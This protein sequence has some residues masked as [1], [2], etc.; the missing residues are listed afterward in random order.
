MSLIT[1]KFKSSVLSTEAAYYVVIPDTV[2]E[3]IPVVYLLH[4]YSGDHT[5]WIRHSRCERYANGRGVALV[6][7]D[8]G[9]S[10]FTDMRYGGAY[11]THVAREVFEHS[12]K[13]F[14]LSSR[15]DATFVA[16][17]SMGG[18]GAFKIAL[19]EPDTYAAACSM[20]GALCAHEYVHDEKYKGLIEQLYGPGITEAPEHDDLF[21]L[22]ERVGQSGGARPRMLQFC[23]TE[24]YLYPHNEKFRRFMDGKGFDYEYRECPGEHEWRLWDAWLPEALDFFLGR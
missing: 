6:M 9:N 22:V 12:H 7:P 16:G 2:S 18:Y 5:S 24:D 17:L 3:D 4:G 1:C 20:S 8:G 15:R 19:R 21:K 11:Y 14:N 10:F 23:G 13:L